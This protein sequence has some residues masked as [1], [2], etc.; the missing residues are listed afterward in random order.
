MFHSLRRSSSQREAI[1]EAASVT[2]GSTEREL[3]DAML[4]VHKSI[5]AERNA[6]AHG[7][8]GIYTNLSDMVVWMETK[9]YV[10]IRARME[11]GNEAFTQDEAE[12]LYSNMYVYKKADLERIFED[13]KEAAEMWH[14][15][16]RYLQTPLGDRAELYGRICARNR[17]LQELQKLRRDKCPPC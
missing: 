16:I 3:L 1:S 11:L 14:E 6:L 10:D 15:F 2:L 7:H 8:F 9:V 17:I 5:E 4:N 13:I 12:T